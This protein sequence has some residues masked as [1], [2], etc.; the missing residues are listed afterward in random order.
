MNTHTDYQ[1]IEY[2]GHPAFVLVPW[3][4]FN[5]V[6]PYLEQS[7]IMVDTIPHAVV[8]ANVLHGVPIIKAWRE[9]LGMTQDEV[10]KKIGVKQPSLA[11]IESGTVK[12]RH[13]TIIKLST[14]FGIK[15]SL[16]EE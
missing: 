8:E 16:L 15:P 13:A 2:N 12:P 14:I 4:Q 7:E 10:A 5:L 3:E 1:T 9:H 6:R 11:R